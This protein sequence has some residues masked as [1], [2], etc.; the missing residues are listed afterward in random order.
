MKLTKKA[1]IHK[2]PHSWSDIFWGDYFRNALTQHLQPCLN[3]LFGFHLLKIGSLSSEIHTESC[4]ISH[5]VN[6]GL[7]GHN[8]HVVADPLHLPF[9]AKSVDACLL[10]HTLSWSQDPHQL[11]REVDRVLIDDGWLVIS[12]F[13][14]FSL[15]GLGKLLPWLGRKGPCSGRMFSQRRLLDWFS[16]LNYEVTYRTHFQV[17]PW[18][19][20]GGEMISTHL[21]ALGCLNII[22]ARKRTF[23]LTP[24]AAKRSKSRAGLRPVVNATPQCRKVVKN[25]ESGQ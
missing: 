4:P 7:S 25:H 22:V 15:L 10:I 17:L 19:K 9:K 5:Q 21:P 16:L 13:N 14:P 6:I 11:L 2:S 1:Q 12:G 23:P 3:K 24:T 8:Q 18:S 20:Q